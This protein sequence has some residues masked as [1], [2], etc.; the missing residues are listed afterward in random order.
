MMQSGHNLAHVMTAELSWHVQNHDLIGLS[1]PIKAK[2]IVTIFQ[3]W[4]CKSFVKWIYSLLGWSKY[5]R[6][7]W[8]FTAICFLGSNW[9]HASIGSGND[10]VPSNQQA[11]TW[12]ND[13]S[14]HWD[15]LIS[16]PQFVNLS[17]HTNFEISSC[18]ICILWILNH[19]VVGNTISTMCT[20]KF[21]K[22]H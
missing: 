11:I 7:D 22:I 9:Q 13:V 14:N 6:L 5:V 19:T 3:S 20:Q 18:K 4:D 8:S 1:E 2:W 17:I 15:I 21:Y 16:R 10:L 12:T